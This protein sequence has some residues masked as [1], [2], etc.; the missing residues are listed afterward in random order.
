MTAPPGRTY[1]YYQG[2]PLFEFG[3][4]LSYSSFSYECQ[5]IN[6][7]ANFS[8]FVDINVTY[9]NILLF[10]FYYFECFW[11]WKHVGDMDGDDV[12]LV[13]HQASND[14]IQSVNHPG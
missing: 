6:K 10:F 12:F 2:E 7:S 4:G 3:H 14:I 9:K 11:W 5:A 13:Y 8:G 1:K